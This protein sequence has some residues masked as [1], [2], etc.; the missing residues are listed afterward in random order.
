MKDEQAIFLSIL[1]IL[2]LTNKHEKKSGFDIVR[3]K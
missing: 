1:E 3:K 2:L